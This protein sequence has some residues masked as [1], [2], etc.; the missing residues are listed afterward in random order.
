MIG[1]LP[2]IGAN[3]ALQTSHSF[4]HVCIYIPVDVTS[5]PEQEFMEAVEYRINGSEARRVRSD[6]PKICTLGRA[7]V[8]TEVCCTAVLQSSR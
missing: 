1:W 6:L 4:M 8:A 5:S 7:L 2:L 3:E